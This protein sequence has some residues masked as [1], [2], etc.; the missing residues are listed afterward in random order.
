MAAEEK[1]KDVTAPLPP[2]SGKD[3]FLA[4]LFRML[5]DPAFM[6]SSELLTQLRR[7]AWVD[8]RPPFIPKS[9]YPPIHLSTFLSI[10]L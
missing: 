10:C 6:G 7:G 5:R 2:E 4:D 8:V 9:I 1:E 3:C